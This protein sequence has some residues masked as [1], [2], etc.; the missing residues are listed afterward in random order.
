MLCKISIWIRWANIKLA[1]R[2]A[3]EENSFEV[4]ALDDPVMEKRSIPVCQY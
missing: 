3:L 4:D 2:M 1:L